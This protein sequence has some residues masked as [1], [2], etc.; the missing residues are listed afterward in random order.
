MH[1]LSLPGR[2]QISGKG[3][4][5]VLNQGFR[6]PWL[7]LLGSYYPRALRSPIS[8]VCACGGGVWEEKTL[9]WRFDRWF[10][11]MQQPSQKYRKTQPLIPVLYKCFQ[12]LWGSTEKVPLLFLN[13]CKGW[14]KTSP[15]PPR[16][17][18]CMPKNMGG[19]Y[20][21]FVSHRIFAERKTSPQ[22]KCKGKHVPPCY[23][24]FLKN[25]GKGLVSRGRIGVIA[26]PCT[27][28][29]ICASLVL[30]NK[31]HNCE[32]HEHTLHINFKVE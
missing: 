27:T 21:C 26:L 16:S 25:S 6:N 19:V 5:I 31:K 18:L 15:P 29:G 13:I 12:R 28:G 30:I 32:V 20:S 22:R 1:N 3:I 7:N 11:L 8:S 2:L 9:S 24:Q 10:S 17:Y 23:L 14:N 4:W